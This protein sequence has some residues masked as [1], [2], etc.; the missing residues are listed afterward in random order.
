MEL[1]FSPLACSLASR[2]ALYEAGA[3]ARFIQVDSKTKRTIDGADY[4]GIYPLGMVPLLR[5]EDGSLLP[6]GAAILQYI[7][8]RFPDAGLAP[9]DDIERARLQQWLGF[10]GTEIHKTLFNPL[11][12]KS[13]SEEAKTQVRKKGESRLAYLNDHLTGREFL[14]DRFTVA[15]AYLYT[16]LNWAGVTQVDLSP[17]AAI[18]S[19]Q[20][21]LQ[22]RPSI[23]KAF[24]EELA[25]Y[26]AEQARHQ[27]A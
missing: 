15:D 20:E 6:E 12:D 19:Y 17:Y 23:A 22:K 9:R 4:R 10:I 2:I 13:L 3:D 26:Q 27:A 11:F 24:K 18:K 14:L 21:R 16:V 5:L 8:S 25:L 1:Y 7:A